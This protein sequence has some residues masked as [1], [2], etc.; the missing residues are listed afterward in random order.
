MARHI[1]KFLNEDYSEFA[2]YRIFQ[3]I[4]HILDSLGQTQRKILYVMEDLPETK[5]VKTAEIYSHVYSKTQYLHGDMSV[6]NVAENMAR[7]CSNNLNMLTNEGAFGNRTAKDA[8]SPRYTSTRFSKIARCIFR[9]ED[10]AI[11]ETQ[12]FEGNPIEP[13]FLLPI[14][15]IS[16]I[17]GYS[18]IAVGFASKFISR[19]P[20]SVIESTVKALRYKKRKTTTK[21]NWDAYKLDQTIPAFPFYSGSIHHDTNHDNDSSWVVTG[22]LHKTKRRNIIEVTDVPPEES[23]EGYIK[24]LKRMQDKGIIKS[25][26]EGCV[27][28]KFKFT[29]HVSPEIWKISEENLLSTLGLVG[30]ISENFTFLNP[31]GDADSTVLKFNSAEEYLK[32]FI[33]LRQEQYEFRRLYQIDK[34]KEEILVLQERIHFI[35]NVNSGNIIITKRKKKD[36]E[37]ELADK[38]YAKIDESFDH[39]LGMKM[40]A[41]TLENIERFEKMISDKMAELEA[42]KK[43]T[44]EDMHIKELLELQKIMRQELTEKEL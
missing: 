24:K 35:N 2:V 29:L 36:L 16:L 40:Y 41:L 14:I 33:E 21:A 7:Q 1:E 23:R 11:L 20:D 5:K 15:P 3:R 38:G 44:T 12:E 34:I 6:Y 26:T 27:K 28:N 25:Y 37:K 18:A 10:D 4:P 31:K 8:A 39:L 42:L 19:H 30:R 17:N 32:F 13:K 22:K 9:K 43:T